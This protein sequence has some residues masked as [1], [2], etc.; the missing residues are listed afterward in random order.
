[1]AGSRERIFLRACAGLFLGQ[2]G[3]Y[4]PEALGLRAI[5]RIALFAQVS[6]LLL[7]ESP[8][9]FGRA[10]MGLGGASVI[11]LLVKARG[12]P[13]TH[14]LFCRIIFAGSF[15]TLPWALVEIVAPGS[16]A[17]DSVSLGYGLWM[18][19]GGASSRQVDTH[20]PGESGPSAAGSPAPAADLAAPCDDPASA[21]AGRTP[22]KTGPSIGSFRGH[23]IPDWIMIEDGRVFHFDRTCTSPCALNEGEILLAPGLIYGTSPT[24]DACPGSGGTGSA[25]PG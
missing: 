24:Q 8:A 25:P 14:T 12:L 4:A 17:L 2:R 10:A 11:L 6:Y 5:L 15:A 19:L 3:W 23:A 21:C 1:M 7:I 20:E 18:I 22:M 16:F 9:A 13:L